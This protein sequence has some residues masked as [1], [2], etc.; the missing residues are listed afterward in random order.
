MLFSDA[1]I[2]SNGLDGF[3]QLIIHHTLL[4]SPDL[5]RVFRIIN[6]WNGNLVSNVVRLNRSNKFFAFLDDFGLNDVLFTVVE[7]MPHVAQRSF[8]SKSFVDARLLY[9]FVDL[10]SFWNYQRIS[11][12]T[13]ILFYLN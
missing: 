8:N 2:A 3:L 1:S 5:G 10:E 9:S 4:V 11:Q 6:I 13:V 12:K 7:K